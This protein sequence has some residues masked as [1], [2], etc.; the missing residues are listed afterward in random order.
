MI[1]I[2]ICSRQKDV[3]VALRQNIDDT[4][5]CQYELIVID[6]SRNKQS[7]FTAYNEGVKEAHGDILCFMHEDIWFHTRDWGMAVEKRFQSDASLGLIGNLGSHFM[8]KCVCALG[9][10]GLLSSNYYTRDKKEHFRESRYFDESGCVEVVV[11]DGMWYCIRRQLFDGRKI[12][13]DE[14]FEGFH[15]YDLDICMQVW[16]AGYKC[17]VVDDVEMEHY[18]EGDIDR[19][20]L[21]NSF[22]FFDKWK[23]NLPMLKGVELTETEYYLSA[24]LSEISAYCRE[25][26]FYHRRYKNSFPQRVKRWIKKHAS[27][28]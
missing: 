14:S 22:R 10:S 21:N 12:W 23:D 28:D 11:V 15:Y 27:K 9:D 20:F 19:T 18:S 8:P 3:S 7:I 6:N 26:S 2:I 1:S 4:I 17:I 5:G 16:E 25:L 13:Y 24:K